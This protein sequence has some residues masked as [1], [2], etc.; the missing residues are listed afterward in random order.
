MRTRIAVVYLN[1]LMLGCTP[2]IYEAEVTTF[3][4]AVNQSAAA[5]RGFNDRAQANYKQIVLHD[6]AVA[7]T[8]ITT[9]SLE[10]ANPAPRVEDDSLMADAFCLRD[11]VEWRAGPSTEPT[12]KCRGDVTPAIARGELVP[13][14]VSNYYR[15]QVEQCELGLMLDD[16]PPDRETLQEA[17]AFYDESLQLLP[18]LAG[19]ADALAGIVSA[20]D[21]DQ[22]RASVG[23][24]KTAIDKQIQQVNDLA[25][26][27]RVPPAAV[28]GVGELLGAGLLGILDYRR[29]QALRNVVHQADPTISASANLLSQLSLPLLLSERNL[30]AKALEDSVVAANNL[31]ERF[32]DPQA[33]ERAW[34]AAY[35]HVQSKRDAYL[36]TLENSPTE[37]FAAMAEAHTRL[38]DRLQDSSVPYEELRAALTDFLARAEAAYELFTSNIGDVQPDSN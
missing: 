36:E 35:A 31:K 34:F 30:K 21:R 9:T 7:G 29:L 16:G 38:D 15:S 8:P 22:L 28:G 23:Q 25:G 3:R 27:E 6:P 19:Y 37:L 5:F 33:R 12:P 26:E 32:P 17:Q 18:A 20:E 13:P 1:L 2:Y 10:C 24:A 11:W 4:D 14:P